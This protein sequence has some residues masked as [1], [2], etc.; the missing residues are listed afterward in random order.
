VT[1]AIVWPRP[2]ELTEGNLWT[3]YECAVQRNLVCAPFARRPDEAA[4]QLHNAGIIMLASKVIEGNNH[5]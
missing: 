3:L 5:V 4:D 1:I 2:T